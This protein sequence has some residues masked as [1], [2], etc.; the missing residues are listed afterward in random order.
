MPA[1]KKAT[2]KKTTPATTGSSEFIPYNSMTPREK[3][4]F[5]QGS[6]AKENQFKDKLGIWRKK[7]Q[8]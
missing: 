3:Q 8:D 5:K 4:A 6:N 1:S 7:K 2:T